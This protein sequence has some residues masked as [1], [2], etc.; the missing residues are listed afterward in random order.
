[1]PEPA[2]KGLALLTA[3]AAAL[4]IS[5]TAA[6]VLSLSFKRLQLTA[7]RSDRAVALAA[8]EAGLQ[9][10][11]IRLDNDPGFRAAVR[12]RTVVAGTPTAYVISC[13]PAVANPNQ[14]VAGLHSGPAHAQ[15]AV[16]TGGKHVT[17]RLT[18]FRPGVDA[19]PSGTPARPYQVVAETLYGTG[20]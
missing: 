1:M 12:N 14:F 13:D 6:L 7:F 15:G 16:G 4:V 5:V 8:G 17:V 18:F 10:S 3:V 11:F 9:Y 19:P 2:E 20:A